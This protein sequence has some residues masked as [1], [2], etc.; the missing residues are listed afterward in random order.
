MIGDLPVSNV[1]RLIPAQDS[2]SVH[3]LAV[4]PEADFSQVLAEAAQNAANSLKAGEKTA[5]AGLSG[6][7]SVQ[8]VAEAIM[9]AERALETSIAIRDKAVAAYLELSRMQI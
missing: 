9:E 5:A 6:T 7:A 8:Q 4:G 3:Q 1:L 2:A